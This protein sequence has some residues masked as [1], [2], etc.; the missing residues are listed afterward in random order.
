MAII[1]PLKPRLS[2]TATKVVVLCIWIL[3]FA[4]AFPLGFYSKTVQT[5]QRTL[6]YV[7]WP[8]RFTDHFMY[9]TIVTVLV[10]LIPLVIMGITYTIVGIT[11]WGGEIPGDTSD[12][13]HE[14]LKAKRKVI[15][16]ILIY[17]V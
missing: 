13:Y 7:D 9:H 6:C 16:S 14:Q 10:Y 8:R 2:A 12:K 4:L 3:A 1:H 11:L 5:P 15:L 17:N